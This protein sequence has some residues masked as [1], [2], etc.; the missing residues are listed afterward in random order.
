MKSLISKIYNKIALSS[1]ESE[2]FLRKLYW[3]NVSLLSFLSPNKSNRIYR[4]EELIFDDVLKFLS[5]NGVVEG[6]N[7][8]VHSSYANLKPIA[9]S[10]REVIEELIKLIGEKGTI[11]MPVIR[12]FDEDKLTLKEQLRDQIKDITCTYDVQKSKVTSGVLAYT[13]MKFPESVTSNFPLNPLTA[14]GPLSKAMMKNNLEGEAPSAH[15]PNSSWKFCADNDAF[16]IYLGV[17]FGHHLTMQ[18]VAA[19]SN[20]KWPIKDFYVERKFNIIDGEESLNKTIKER[21]LK[22]T[23]YLA[24]KNVRRELVNE[25]IVKVTKIKEVPV[26]ILKA[27]ELFDF[28]N[29]H[30]NPTYPYYL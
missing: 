29:N 11:A 15:G 25:G 2:V 30:K 27:K 9:L 13:L 7:I 14:F 5:D 6:T 22:W 12:K 28:Y 17:D 19:E 3:K 16:V 20:I 8:V 10:P 23:M 4:E 21:R 24:E 26:C 18:Q 1:P